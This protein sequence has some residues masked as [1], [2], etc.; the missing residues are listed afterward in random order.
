MRVRA[1]AKINLSLRVLGMRAGG[2]HELQTIF[3]S[4]ALHDT[5]TIRA[6]RGPFR[7]TCDDPDCPSDDTNLIWRAAERLWTVSGRQRDVRDISIDLVKRIPRQAGLGGGSSDAAAALRALGRLWRVDQARLRATAAEMGA[8]VPYFLEGGTALGLERGD[9]LFPLIDYPPAWV[10]LVLPGFGVSTKDAFG[11][12]DQMG[13]GRAADASRAEREAF[14]PNLRGCRQPS[15]SARLPPSRRGFGEPPKLAGK[16]P[17]SGG[18]KGSPS[19]YLAIPELQNDL[20]APVAAHHPQIA[21]LVRAMRQAGAFHAA[22]TGSGSAVFGL[23]GRRTAAASAAR[24]LRG[25]ASA[26][27][28]QTLVTR[29]LNRMRY[30]ALARI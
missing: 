30:R 6:A 26:R 29:T 28:L 5:L 1:F 18:G 3:Q 11:W 7:L 2:Y 17:A 12:F 9:R 27:P 4:I 10:V 13:G 21:R 14:I 24:A 19:R 25:P 22:M 20:E 8:D 23:F 15:G 16:F